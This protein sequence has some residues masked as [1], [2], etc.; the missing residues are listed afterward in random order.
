M[1]RCHWSKLMVFVLELKSIYDGNSTSHLDVISVCLYGYRSTVLW[2]GSDH[3]SFE[4]LITDP[5]QRLGQHQRMTRIL[6][7]MQVCYLM[8]FFHLI[9][10]Q[11]YANTVPEHLWDA[12]VGHAAI[13]T[14]TMHISD[15]TSTVTL[16]L[17]SFL[18][19]NRFLTIGI[20]VLLCPWIRNCS[21]IMAI[22]SPLRHPVYNIC[23]FSPPTVFLS[24][25]G[26]T[27]QYDPS[28]QEV[29]HKWP[30]Q[31]TPDLASH[32]APLKPMIFLM[33]PCFKNRRRLVSVFDNI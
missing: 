25:S 2:R 6:A 7:I 5:S 16:I 28:Y 21:S 9:T 22:A 20:E 29:I 30:F 18:S 32:K 10:S 14:R 1:G 24:N 17:K 33:T 26:I 4:S 3:V 8:K 11:T 19:S 13:P 15:I 23:L 27:V 12:H 31:I